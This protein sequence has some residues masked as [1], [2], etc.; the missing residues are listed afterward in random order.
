M[1]EPT[2]QP[3]TEAT[4]TV[5]AVHGNGGGSTRFSLV[6]RHLPAHV[7]FVAVDLPGFNGA[8][9][10]PSLQSVAAYADRLADLLEE[11]AG[12]AGEGARD[13]A[14]VEPVRPIVLGHGIGGS[15]AL[16][17]ASR[18]PETM[19]GLILHAPV[20]ADLDSRLFPRI[21]ATEP[22]RAL[23]RTLIA[24]RP[25]RPIWRRV[26]FPIGAPAAELDT[27]FEGYRTCEA[28]SRM[29]DIIN[30]EW[31]T[32]LDPVRAVPTV[33]LWGENDRVLKSGQADAIAAKAPEART[34][35]R[36]GWDHFP[37]LEQP[38][39]YAH[40]VADLATGLVADQA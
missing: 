32:A 7:R 20:G 37:M 24:A 4:T 25:L 26:F 27:F 6:P 18:R 30:V 17:L 10:D 29:F 13:G 23:V 35:I 5:V 12:P 19:S 38:E 40:V 28:F 16:D 14:G 34:V 3:T 11:A 33:L 1:T 2:P 9:D 21:M 8:P 15:I 31:F 22:V 39:E 36:D